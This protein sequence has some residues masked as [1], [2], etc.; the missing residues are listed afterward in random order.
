MRFSLI[1]N[2]F[3]LASNFSI[4]SHHSQRSRVT[5]L[6]RHTPIEAWRKNLYLMWLSKFIA[7]L[8]M[9]LVVP[10]LPFFVRDLGVH[11]PAEVA[12][13]SGLVFAGPFFLSFIMTPIWGALGDRYGRKLMVVRAIFGLGI[14][15]VLMGFSTSVEMLFFFRLLQGGI[16]GFIASALALVAATTP[17]QKSGYA[18]GLLQS[19]IAGGNVVGPLL[20]GTLAD[21]V[22]F[23]PIFFI[24]A[25]LCF[26]S[27]TLVVLFVK[28][29]SKGKISDS[30]KHTLLSNYRF[31]L[32]SH[33]IRIALVIILFSQLAMYMIQPI[34]ALF[35]EFLAGGSRYLATLAG[36]TFSVAGVFMVISSPWWGKRNDAKSYKKNLLIAIT[37]AAFAY[38]LQGFA[39]E[40]S[41]LIFLRAIQGFCMGGILPT[42]FSYVSKNTEITRRGGV[43]GIASS[44]QLLAN[45]IGPITGGFVAA[46]V[47]LR[48]N[49]FLTGSIL[50]LTSLFVYRTFIDVRSESIKEGNNTQ[51]V[52]ESYQQIS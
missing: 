38:A 47:G 50:A 27:G 16:S 2:R 19:A 7:M 6:L 31:A 28:E 34:F 20:G 14:S 4:F 22:G 37:G 15:Q 35:V 5:Y 9:S 43:M 33:H 44:M 46:H 13:W 40:V 51:A 41:H 1:K 32:N 10:F 12:T 3:L 45:M 8:G 23:R 52:V 30:S 26:V 11:D 48:E 21:A 49:F 17:H 42:L 18:I 29:E 24:V 39:T 36:A 25:A